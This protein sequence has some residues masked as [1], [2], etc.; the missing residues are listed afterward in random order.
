MAS[1]FKHPSVLDG[2]MSNTLQVSPRAISAKFLLWLMLPFVA[3]A[4][5]GCSHTSSASPPA[6]QNSGVTP[7]AKE[8][9]N[10]KTRLLSRESDREDRTIPPKPPIGVFNRV[11]YPAPLGMNAAYVTPDPANGKR[12]PAIIWISGGYSN[13]LGDFYWSESD[14]ENDQT[15]SAFRQDGLVLMIPSFRGSHFNRGR[16]E[17]FLGEADD[18]FAAAEYL[19]NLP[20]VDPNRI[21]LGGHSTG[22]TLAMLVAASTDRFR[23]VFAFGP[24]E[25]VAGYG[26]NYLPFDMDDPR[27]VKIR[28]PG[29]WL[30]SIASPTYVIEG[31]EEPGNYDDLMAMKRATKNPRVRFLAAKGRDHYNLLR[32]IGEILARKIIAD[33]GKG[34]GV[35]LNE[36]DL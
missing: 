27:E 2:S 21:Y 6:E 12:L 18:V 33:D 14:P 8:R 3:T 31:A 24:V 1:F 29:A 26:P 34:A 15:A 23:G 7:L 35:T 4:Q 32:P 16:R 28:S 36:S 5:L 13:I 9:S 17:A 19:S 11:L 30:D 22:A 10:F 25:D 20:Y